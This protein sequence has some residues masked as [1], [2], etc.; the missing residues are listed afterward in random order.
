M[1]I[2]SLSETW[3]KIKK[4]RKTAQLT[5]FCEN[6]VDNENKLFKRFFLLNQIDYCLNQVE[7]FRKDIGRETS[8]YIFSFQK[9][10]MQFFYSIKFGEVDMHGNSKKIKF[11]PPLYIFF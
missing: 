3:A 7:K 2:I 9:T 4:F 6:I 5:L 10:K 1:I 11:G 8:K